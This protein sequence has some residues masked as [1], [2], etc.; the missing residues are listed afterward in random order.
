M[1]NLIGAGL[2]AYYGDLGMD[3]TATD[4][5]WQMAVVDFV[6]LLAYAWIVL[7]IRRRR[8]APMLPAQPA[9]EPVESLVRR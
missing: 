5:P 1:N 9:E 7:R 2:A 6:A 3:E 8:A 4:M